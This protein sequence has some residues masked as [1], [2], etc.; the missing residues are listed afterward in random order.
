MKRQKKIRD[1]TF[2]STQKASNTPFLNKL[3]VKFLKLVTRSRKERASG[4][5]AE[6]QLSQLVC[7]RL[8]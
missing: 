7:V 4:T 8:H 1:A 6:V 3:N 2:L 5:A